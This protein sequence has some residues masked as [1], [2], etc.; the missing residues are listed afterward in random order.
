MKFKISKKSIKKFMKLKYFR[1]KLNIN[2]KK[3]QG[4][5]DKQFSSSI[6]H[7][8]NEK[9]FMMVKNV[10]ISIVRND[11]T[12]ENVDVVGLLQNNIVNAANN[13][14]WHGGGVACAIKKAAG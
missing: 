1:I 5:S 2:E 11:I 12:K 7:D 6:I 9:A 4:T 13:D 8:P 3:Y 14:L 10:R